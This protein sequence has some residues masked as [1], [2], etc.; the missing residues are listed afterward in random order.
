M[1][2]ATRS[3]TM[4]VTIM[5]VKAKTNFVRSDDRL[6]QESILANSD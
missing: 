3:N 5:P 6:S 1:S 4:E 2:A